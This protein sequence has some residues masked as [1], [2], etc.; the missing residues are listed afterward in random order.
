MEETDNRN[1]QKSIKGYQIVIVILALVL[2]ALSF[3]YFHQTNRMKADFAVERDTLENHLS[4]IITDLDNLKTENDTI[5]Y[6]LGIEREKA[7]SLMERLQ[8]ERN[9]SANKIRQYEKE[10]GTMREVMRGFVYQIDSLN[11][12][13][14]KLITENV[15][16]RKQITTERL[17]ADMAEEKADEMSTKIRK[18]SVVIARGISLVAL[19]ANDK[20]VTRAS[21]AVRLGV[22]FVL[23]ANELAT[24]GERSVYARITGPD[25]YIMANAGNAVFPFEGDQLTYSATREI[26]YQNKDLSVRVYYTGGGITEGKYQVSIYMDGYKI[27][28]NEIILK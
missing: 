9:F 21:R 6:N 12:L 25:G 23:T 8:K 28:S 13:N 10:L 7:D 15:D 19:N 11:T 20:E 3:M 18:G 17:R 5:N 2:G 27:G 24:P 26:D 1:A 16:I 4:R 22:D 14:K